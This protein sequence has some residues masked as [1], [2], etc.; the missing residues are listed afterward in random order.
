[1]YV[2]FVDD[3]S[4][5]R[6]GIA[7]MI[8][9]LD[10][11]W[12]VEFAAD[13]QSALDKLARRPADVVV[14]D[15]RMPG[16]DGAQLLKEVIRRT[17]ETMRIVL[18]GH[19]DEDC[20][21]RALGVA[22][23]FLCKP[24]RPEDLVGA[25]DRISV[26]RELLGAPEVQAV[27]A[28]VPGLPAAPR[29][30]SRLTQ[31]LDDPT[32]GTHDVADIIGADPALAAK[33]LQVSNSAF[34]CRPGRAIKDIG[35]AV[36]R[37]GIR[38][39]RQ[40]ALVSEVFGN[41]GG[42]AEHEQILAVAASHL[43]RVI[44]QGRTEAEE[45]A[46]SALLAHV[47]ALLPRQVIDAIESRRQKAVDLSGPA[48]AIAGAHLLGM[49]GLPMGVV[50]AVA[51][52]HAPIGSREQGLTATGVVHVAT[53][54]VR[55]E[56]IDEAYLECVGVL[57]QLPQWRAAALELQSEMQFGRTVEKAPS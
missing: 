19:S 1:M 13:G 24:C 43:A 46:T 7:R 3:E 57:D 36:T 23:R 11:D 17:P 14:S 52:H 54:L 49:W 25:V 33:L 35:S 32:I 45:A 5:V 50:E 55:D 26:L 56:P 37:L 40:I 34:F 18:S 15:M 51:F 20:V 39:L 41:A 6:D 12:E 30:F 42:G 16:M 27:M 53:A 28:G 9:G 38:T 4:R 47:G 8:Y 21:L 31:L 48:H 22:H 10:L 44:A 2:M 29:L